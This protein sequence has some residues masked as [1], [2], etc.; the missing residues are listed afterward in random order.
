MWK[1]GLL[2]FASLLVGLIVIEL[3]ARSLGLSPDL[4]AIQKPM[5]LGADHGWSLPDDQLAWVNRPGRSLAEQPGHA[6]MTFLDHG[7]RLSMAVDKSTAARRVMVVGCSFTQ[8]FGVTDA[9]TYVYRLN[10]RF[11]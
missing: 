8:G 1:T 3:A 2:V 11:P 9:E 10:D 7:R 4:L 6:P 5:T